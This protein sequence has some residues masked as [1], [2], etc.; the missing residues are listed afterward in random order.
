MKGIDSSGKVS[1]KEFSF[2]IPE[3]V[4]LNENY[5]KRIEIAYKL[6][7]LDKIYKEKVNH[8]NYITID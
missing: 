2:N 7:G 1:Y 4:S 5:E 8:K 3:H 6:I